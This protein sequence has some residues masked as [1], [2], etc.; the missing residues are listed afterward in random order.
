M[1]LRHGGGDWGLGRDIPEI[2]TRGTL[3]TA[4]EGSGLRVAQDI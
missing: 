1:I 3:G 2:R 4:V